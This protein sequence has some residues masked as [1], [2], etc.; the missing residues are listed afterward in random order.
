MC[1]RKASPYGHAP[2]RRTVSA[3]DS[4]L[5]P[6]RAVKHRPSP[7]FTPVHGLSL[8]AD[9]TATNAARDQAAGFTSPVAWIDSDGDRH[10]CRVV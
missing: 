4:R 1:L 2:G 8:A 3:D 5:W 9:R 6:S 10:Q 7:C